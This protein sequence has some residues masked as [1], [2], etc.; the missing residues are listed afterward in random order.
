MVANPIATPAIIGGFKQD[1]TNQRQSP[2]IRETPKRLAATRA[3]AEQLAAAALALSP[4][5]GG[6]GAHFSTGAS[7]ASKR[8]RGPEVVD[9]VDASQLSVSNLLLS[10]GSSA[11]VSGS[12]DHQTVVKPDPEAYQ[13]QHQEGSDGGVVSSGLPVWPSTP[14]GSAS[15]APPIT[16]DTSR[17]RSGRDESVSFGQ[18]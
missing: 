13:F 11:S 8:I 7:A 9:S 18:L 17:R 15:N 14:L 3:E 16:A 4:T 2:T 6:G 10:N 12:T 1:P 5:T